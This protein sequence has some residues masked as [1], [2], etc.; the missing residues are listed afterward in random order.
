LNSPAKVLYF[1]IIIRIT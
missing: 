1:T